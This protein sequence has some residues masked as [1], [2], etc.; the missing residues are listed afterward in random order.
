MDTFLWDIEVSLD[1]RLLLQYGNHSR[2]LVTRRQQ[3]GLNASVLRKKLLLT[4]RHNIS[5]LNFV[6]ENL[7]LTWVDLSVDLFL[8]G[9]NLHFLLMDRNV[10]R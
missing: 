8:T 1:D 10:C 9:H 5:Q 6:L 4:I 2:T 3:T 7:D